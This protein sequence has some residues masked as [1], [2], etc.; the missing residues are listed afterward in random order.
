[1]VIYSRNGHDFTERFPSIAQLLQ[2]VPAKSA[3]LDGELWPAMLTAVR[4]SPGCTFV[5]P[6]QALSTCGHSTYL[7]SIGRDL[8]Q[9]PLVK[10]QA[11]L[12]GLLGRFG[13]P[14]VSLRPGAAACAEERDLEGIVSKRRDAPYRSGESRDWRKIKTVAWREAN[15]ERWRLFER[16]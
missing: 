4:I 14:A 5:G 10:R 11:R 9:Q 12:Q 6:G 7:R 2:E 3:V 15:R 1:V 16:A 13:C 8:R